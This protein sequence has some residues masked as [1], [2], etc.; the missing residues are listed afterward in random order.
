MF[1]LQLPADDAMPNLLASTPA[2]DG[3]RMPGE[4]EPHA[5]CWMLWPE[6]PDV[7]RARAAYAERAFAS[8]A[9][10]IATSEPVIVGA[11]RERYAQARSMLPAAIR[12]VEL[13]SDDAWMRDVGPTFV[14]NDAGDSRGV[15][16]QFNAWGGAH[17]GLYANWDRDEW[18]ARKVLEVQQSDGYIAP[19]VLEGGAIHVDGCGTVLT[20]EECLLNQNRNP[21]LDVGAIELLLCEYLGASEVIW[22]GKG[23]P[24][25]ETDGHIDELCAFVKPGVV[26]LTWT[27]N[28]R[29]ALYRICRDAYA[30]LCDA[31]DARGRR[32][33]IHKLP[34]PGPL[35]LTKKEAAGVKRAKGSRP[36]RAGE[37]LAASYANF[38][39]GNRAVV[40]PLLDRRYDAQV[41]KLLASLFPKR[42]IIGVDAREIVLG[43]GGIHCI[44]QQVPRAATALSATRDANKKQT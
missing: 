27:D 33:V 21:T 31:R 36:R 43:G 28:K 6:R 14:V 37:R 11:S 22:L 40:M 42:H 29:D 15:V 17:G 32:L 8:V 44:T 20:T 4:F 41:M 34:Q 24:N 12:V 38:F 13:S 5:G 19:F 25:D 3:F 18:V 9:S 16:W 2:A 1:G 7:W 23:I 30:R 35:Y 26:L 10:A 39:I